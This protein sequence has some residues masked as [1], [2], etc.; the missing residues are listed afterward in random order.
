MWSKV[1]G[2]AMLV[3]AVAL[4]ATPAFASAAPAPK[5]L[6]DID[7]GAESQD[8]NHG[9]DEFAKA[10]KH[11]FL[12]AD[13]GRH[14]YELWKSDGTKQGTKL[15]RDIL[16]G[17]S[18]SEP[19]FLTGYGKTLIF[20]ADDGTH[21]YELWR[22]DGTRSG[23]RMVRNIN[24]GATGSDPDEFVS[25]KGRLY[26]AANDGT[27]GV[28]LW[29]TDGT[30]HGTKLVKNIAPGAADSFPFDYAKLD[31]RLYFDAD[32]GTHGAEL[33]RSDGTKA[34]TKLFRN[35]APGSISSSPGNLL[36][37]GQEIFF[38][39]DDGPHGVEPWKTDGTR[40]GTTMVS[41]INPTP[42]AGS[43]ALFLNPF[44]KLGHTVFLRADD[45]V[46]GSDLWVTDG[47][48]A[49]HIEINT[50]GSSVPTDFTAMKGFVYFGASDGAA[51]HGFELW[52]S[53]GT[54]TGTRLVHDI[55]PSGDG[56]PEDF[57][58]AG[59]HLYFA[60]RENGGNDSELWSSNGSDSGTKLLK[61]FVPGA[62]DGGF[63]FPIVNLGG[64]IYLSAR[65]VAHGAEPWV[66]PKRH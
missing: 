15:V 11:V 63:P 22:S 52:R 40:S 38:G 61:E 39:A 42:G 49:Q 33:W 29:R 12:A 18:T 65:D 66:I 9:V 54:T 51:N 64:T 2:L 59:H 27:H 19:Y 46:S 3:V 23:T 26:F 32:D 34:G 53:D 24:P 1:A 6:K 25:F 56:Y 41:D 21:G 58:T 50:T 45:G 36:K 5:L 28:E 20:A 17:P 4:L 16:P 48:P 10:G 7:P 30:R 14:G 35:I 62:T 55:N 44:G 37:A 31:N 8:I 57:A 43:L 13:D 60:A 47:G